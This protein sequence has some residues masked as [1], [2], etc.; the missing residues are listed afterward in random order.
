MANL[1]QIELNN[2][3]YDLKD[4]IARQWAMERMPIVTYGEP[5]VLIDT[6]T[7]SFSKDGNNNWYISQQNPV[8]GLTNSA[9]ENYN[10]LY[11][12][13]WDGTKYNLFLK[14]QQERLGIRETTFGYATFVWEYLGNTIPLGYSC[15]SEEQ[16]CP[17]VIL[18]NYKSNSGEVYIISYDTSTS[19]TLKISTIPFTKKVVDPVLY[20]KTYA[21]IPIIRPGTEEGSVIE[22][23]GTKSSAGGSH[24]EGLG[25]VA[26]GAASHAE[27]ML[28]SS[29]GYGAHS[30][31]LFTVASGNYSH[32]EG[33][34]NEAS[35][36]SS[37]T[38]GQN[39]LASA[40]YAHVEGRGTIAQR[41]SQHVFG[42]YNI[43]D[44]EGAS[45]LVH[46]KYI[47]I[48]GNG[49]ADNARNNAR[50]LD[51]NGNEVLAGKLTVGSAPTNNMDV[52]TK[53]YVDD[54]ITGKISAPSSPATGSF[55]V[56][57]GTTWV[58][59]TLQTWQGGSY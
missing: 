28:N 27:G 34:I 49:T 31:G 29:S 48:V 16:K 14:G 57:N 18:S 3:T 54:G 9:L 37:H 12:V 23:L 8:N 25:T 1:S 40:S 53:K 24:A 41:G 21:G 33:I 32:T 56:Y 45:T 7:V 46:G 47:E 35:G 39:T 30:E 55:L 4:T 15:T 58:A 11:Q 22:G 59:Q 2:I 26:S 43:A 38:E 6:T 51:W 19:H 13:E 50:T 36:Q 20:E 10:Q 44:T 17:F 42:E 5:T 52:A